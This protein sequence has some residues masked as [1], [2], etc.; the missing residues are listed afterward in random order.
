MA[1]PP[2][3]GKGAGGG[4]HG[5]ATPGAALLLVLAAVGALYWPALDYPF[6]SL[7]DHYGVVD[8]PGLRDLSW[9]GLR[10]LFF[11]DRHD[12]RYFPLAWLS[13]ALDL[14]LFGLDPRYFHLTNVLLHLANTALVFWLVQALARDARVAF[15]TALLFGIH[16]LQVESVA[17]VSSRKNVLF[18]LF[19]LLSTL[20]YVAWARDRERR[21]GRARAALGASVLLFLLSATAKTTAV[22]LPAAL[23]LVDHQL[24]PRLP[25][26]PLRFLRE[27]LPVKLLYL[28]VIA[29]VA[30]MTW[31]VAQRSPYGAENDFTAIDWF[32]IA[33]HNLSFYVWKS[34]VPTGLSVFVP[35]PIGPSLAVPL[36]FV[37]LTGLSLVAVGVCAWSFGRHRALFFGLGWYG[38]TILPMVLLQVFFGDIPI[39]V[40][41]RYFYQSSIG[42]FFLA[43]AGALR[44]WDGPLVGRRLARGGGLL[45]GTAGL[46]ALFALAWEQRSVWR[47]TIPLYEQ[48][49]R[50]HPSDAFFNRL[51]MEYADA[52]E[53]RKAFGALELAGRAPHQMEFANVGAYLMRIADLHRR[54]GDFARA[55]AMQEAAIEAT[56]NALEPADAR[57]PLAWRWTAH[58]HELAGDAERARALRQRAASAEVEDGSYFE[59]L[60]F[61]MSPEAAARFLERRVREAP[62]DAVAW[63]YLALLHRL[64]GQ[65]ARAAEYERR[66]AER[67][68]GS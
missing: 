4:W 14:H 55:A 28:P 1:A 10:F 16:P 26:S 36:H 48:V 60:W 3:D 40:A 68:F 6:V 21:P 24:A 12:F 47:G 37:A 27:N 33:G 25:R 50:H 66:A 65:P 7:D 32:F 61:T 56:P 13:L 34:V 53:L 19:F 62:T 67:G 58:L 52:G 31:V 18:L 59:S 41:D 11:E 49:V 15:V 8:N 30:V 42:I 17:W 44:L 20:A 23:L 2:R 54:R 39:L 38:V 22:T 43:G 63:H 64:G 45:L 57:T 29:F 5:L 51:A 9:Q 35:L 46:A